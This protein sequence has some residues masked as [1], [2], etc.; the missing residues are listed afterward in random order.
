M[1]KEV[2]KKPSYVYLFLLF[3]KVSSCTVVSHI[4]LLCPLSTMKLRYRGPSG[5]G[6]LDL[7]DAATVGQLLEAIK[8]NTGYSE[9]TVKYGWPP[10]ALNVDQVDVS[11]QSLGLQRESLTVVPVENP[12]PNVADAPSS[13]ATR[14]SPAPGAFAGSDPPKGIK[15]QNINVPMPETG[16]TLGISQIPNP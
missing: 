5:G 13:S 7:D 2:S 3:T 9:V 11:L 14:P 15:E 1:S 6:T 12:S 10:Q 8:Q 4:I 16:S